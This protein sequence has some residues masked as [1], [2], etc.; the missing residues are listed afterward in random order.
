MDIDE[1]DGA[2]VHPLMLAAGQLEDAFEGFRH[3][4]LLPFA[5]PADSNE[6]SNVWHGL[7]LRFRPRCEEAIVSWIENRVRPEL[8]DETAYFLCRRFDHVAN[9][10]GDLFLQDGTTVLD[11]PGLST[12]EFLWWA[13][14]HWWEARGIGEAFLDDL[15]RFERDGCRT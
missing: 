12:D 4:L 7:E 10:L 15:E 13:L 11:H 14:V 1:E 6:Y 3:D 9:F 2:P 8:E 5:R